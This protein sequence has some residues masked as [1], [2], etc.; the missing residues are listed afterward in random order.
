MVYSESP[1][2]WRLFLHYLGLGY[3]VGGLLWVTWR[4]SQLKS[5]LAL[6]PAI[7]FG[8]TAINAII[9]ALAAIVVWVEYLVSR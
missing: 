2:R 8:I 7:L 5:W 9:L 1:T 6:A 3:L 4:G